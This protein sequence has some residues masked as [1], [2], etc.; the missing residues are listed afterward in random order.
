VFA[1]DQLLGRI[2]SNMILNGFQAVPSGK[3]PVIDVYLETNGA[4]FTIM[5][6]DN[7]VGIEPELIDKIFLPH[8]TTKKTGSGL[9][10]AIAKQGIEQMGGRISFKTSSKG[11]VFR[12]DLPQNT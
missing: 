6:S 12:I 9:G 10:L 7:G 1:D 4:Y 2:F 11:T 8:F 3:F 5:I